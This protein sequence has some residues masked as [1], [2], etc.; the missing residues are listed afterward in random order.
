MTKQGSGLG[1]SGSE[2]LSLPS[3]ISMYSVDNQNG[4]AG[5]DSFREGNKGGKKGRMSGWVK[6]G[7]REIK[8]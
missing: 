6:E 1:V 7:S 4:D 5:G 3:G 2:G 8:A